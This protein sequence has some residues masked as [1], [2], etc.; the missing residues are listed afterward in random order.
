MSLTLR[1]RAI[2]ETGAPVAGASVRREDETVV[3]TDADGVAIVDN[4]RV[5]FASVT[6]SHSMPAEAQL[7]FSFGKGSS[8]VIDCT[9]TLRRGAPLRG[10]VVTPAGTPLP[11][12]IVEVWCENDGTK[13][14]ES[15]SHGNWSVPAMLAGDYEVRAAAE[16]YARGRAI[17]GTHDGRGE[18]QGAVVR[19]AIGARLHGHVRDE[20]GLPV[21]GVRVYT[22]MQPGDDRSTTTDADGRFEICG[23]GAGRHLVGLPHW[24]SSIVMR[25]DGHEQELEIEL[26]AMPAPDSGASPPQEDEPATATLTGRVLRDGAPMS[27][28][29]IVRK[30]LV[31]YRWIT[32]PAMIHASDG[33]FTL[34]ELRESP[35]TVHVLALGSAWAATET[36]ELEPGATLDLGDIALSRGLRIAGT[37][38]NAA[39]DPIAGAHVTIGTPF[40][41]HD[42]LHDA[43]DGNFA[44][45]S[46][47]DGAFVFE[48]VYVR[49]PRV[50]LF[51]C[52]P[53][54]GASVQQSLNGTD[55]TLRVVLVSTG[56]IDGVIEP[57]SV[58]SGGVI[59]RAVAPDGGSRVVRV[60]PSGLFTV[61]NLVPGEYTIEF[62]ERPGWPRREARATVVAGQCTHVRM[63]PP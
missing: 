6:V 32:D 41:D 12:A 46:D 44:T 62:V 24:R 34:A 28:F 10:T 31:P 58:M 54:H 14:L 18:Q 49:D 59:V 8:G 21:A 51:A 55:E 13:F 35:C 25:G 26:P 40:R 22:E 5:G 39:G 20:A 2:D 36:I 19:V 43:V 1:V 52:H 63:P 42:P 56:G 37:V 30:G 38:R 9:M 57:H 17:A 15:D 61:E 11:D 23:L 4:I 45:T 53:V 29:A 33:R 60:R 7:V 16:G 27:R 50:R 47:S 3:T 48:G